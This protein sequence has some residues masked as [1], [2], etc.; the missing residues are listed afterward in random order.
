MPSTALIF[1]SL[2][3]GCPHPTIINS[4]F[5]QSFESQLHPLFLHTSCLH[6]P[7]SSH[8]D[9]S[10][11]HSSQHFCFLP[12]RLTGKTFPVTHFYPEQEIVA[13]HLLPASTS[14]TASAPAPH[15]PYCVEKVFRFCLCLV[16]CL[17][18]FPALPVLTIHLPIDKIN[19]VLNLC[20]LHVKR[21]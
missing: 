12:S 9:D 4:L 1:T 13:V 7:S 18:A 14:C 10:T 16:L 6:Q 8:L 17:F 21:V 19:V 3:L 11:R 20:N 2:A 15:F 5:S